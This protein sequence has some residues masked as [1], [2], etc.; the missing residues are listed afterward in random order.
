MDLFDKP[1]PPP[2]KQDSPFLRGIT[3]P[4]SLCEEK[5]PP[6][7]PHEFPDLFKA[8]E[9][10]A[11][12]P[13][14]KKKRSKEREKGPDILGAGLTPG[15]RPHAAGPG[16]TSPVPPSANFTALATQVAQRVSPAD[17]GRLQQILS[18]PGAS[19]V[20]LV[21]LSASMGGVDPSLLAS[22]RSAVQGSTV[23]VLNGAQQ[24]PGAHHQ[25]GMLG[26]QAQTQ[27]PFTPLPTSG[28]EFPTGQD[29]RSL[30]ALMAA[31]KGE[32][33]YESLP[34]ETREYLFGQVN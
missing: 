4:G 19:S 33:L 10:P 27:P 5:T 8:S 29:G 23:G 2:A 34:P 3:G 21:Q 22:L 1:I 30:A 18:G 24:Q 32:G 16:G 12:Q 20:D 15:G 13:P 17:Y 7:E 26:Q 9:E 14:K 31:Q 6:T 25:H 28:P 11:G